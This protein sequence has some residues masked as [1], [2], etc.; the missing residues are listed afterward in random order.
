MRWG[1]KVR[2]RRIDP[3]SEW[4]LDGRVYDTREEYD[5]AV[6]K[7]KARRDR[8]QAMLDAEQDY[9]RGVRGPV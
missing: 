8:L 9:D 2:Q 7:R 4:Q 1:R 5:A 3:P 6:A